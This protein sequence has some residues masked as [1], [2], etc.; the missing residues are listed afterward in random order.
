MSECEAKLLIC[1]VVDIVHDQGVDVGLVNWHDY[2]SCLSVFLRQFF[3]HLYALCVYVHG[4]N[5]TSKDLGQKEEA[6]FCWANR[7]GA[8]KAFELI[9]NLLLIVG[10]CYAGV[11]P[12]S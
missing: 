2:N 11:G 6:R 8:P 1:K 10:P 12:S 4:I 3:E 9:F 5:Q 7:H